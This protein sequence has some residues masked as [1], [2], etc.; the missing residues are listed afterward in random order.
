MSGAWWI[1]EEDLLD[2][3]L[4]VL[5]LD[6]DQ[7]LLI[8]GPPG[9]GKTNLL[10]LR[11]NHLH[12]AEQPE[13]YVVAF[14][15]LLAN[16]I[17]TG[18]KLY[19]FPK[20]KVTTQ[21]KLY[22][23]VLADHGFAVPRGNNSEGFEG[24]KSALREGVQKLMT[25]GKGKHSFPALFIDE[26]QDYDRFDLEAFFYL[27]KSV[28]LTADSRQGIYS[29][30]E[31][32]HP[33]LRKQCGETVTLVHHY[34][35]G[36]NILKVAD[37]LM[38][39]KLGHVPMLPTSQYKEDDLP[40]SVDLVGPVEL[41][42]QVTQTA[43]RLLR[44][45]RAYPNET[46]GVLIPRKKEEFP[47]VWDMLCKIPA[48]NGLITNALSSDFDPTRP[49]W[50]S[51]IHSAKG[52][53]FRCVHLLASDTILKFTDHSRRVAFTAITRAKTALVIYFNEELPPFLSAALATK[54]DEKI[55]VRKLFGKTS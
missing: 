18:A 9:S 55:S 26:A 1:D 14:T 13:F 11:A 6:L 47:I 19:S 54:K 49:I 36:K 15:G 21:V 37:R 4:Q 45:L 46:L 52:L 10:L 25:S 34:R 22:E 8:E 48:I 43:E 41:G 53:E 42:I 31:A 12:I 20:T 33:W 5:G 28:C 51:T 27:A 16:F 29:R 35:T 24:R 7:H 50:V 30:D 44:Q 32:D 17:K 2:E 38:D 40:S 3:Q 23:S 39:G